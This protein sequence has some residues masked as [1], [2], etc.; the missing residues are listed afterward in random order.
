MP[1]L[2]P[3]LIALHS[4]QPQNLQVNWTKSSPNLSIVRSYLAFVCVCHE[5]FI[6]LY[7]IIYSFMDVFLACILSCLS[8]ASLLFF[9]F[10]FLRKRGFK[11]KPHSKCFGFFSNKK[12]CSYESNKKECCARSVW[13]FSEQNWPKWLAR[14]FCCFFCKEFSSPCR[15]RIFFARTWVNANHFKKKKIGQCIVG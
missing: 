8:V 5:Y 7:T 9:I 13:S 12:S 11:K 14:F 6:T 1:A 10:F 4:P 3:S 2:P 15:V